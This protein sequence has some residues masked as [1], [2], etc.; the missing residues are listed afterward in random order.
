MAG[1]AEGVADGIGRVAGGV[2][3]G[4]RSWGSGS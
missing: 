4:R 1:G 3:S 2:V